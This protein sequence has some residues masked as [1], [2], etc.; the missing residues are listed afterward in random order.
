MKRQA[1]GGAAEE[2]ACAYL[3]SRGLRLLE[4]IYRC[5]Y[6]EIDLIMQ[7]GASLV[8]V[9]VRLRRN[10]NIGGALV[11]VDRLQRGRL[12]A[13]AQHYLQGRAGSCP[14]RF[15]VIAIDTDERL[16]WVRNAFE[17]GE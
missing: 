16:Q 14:A 3:L 2:R 15:D 17:A 9:E 10:P 7:D 6:G 13:S 4:R 11:S 8:F 12:A 1:S 5:R